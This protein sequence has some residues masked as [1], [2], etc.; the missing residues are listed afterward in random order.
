MNSM[1]S[2]GEKM[3]FKLSLAEW[4]FNQ[5]LFGRVQP[6]LDN[7]DFASEAK[8]LG[9]DAV[10][11]VNQFFMSKAKDAAYIND[12]KKRAADNGVKSLLIMCDQEGNI[13]DPNENQRI[14]V[15]ENHHKWA[16]AAKTLGCHSIRVNAASSG[17]YEEQQK[18]TADG[19]R[20]L[21]EYAKTL[22]LNVLVENHGGNSSIADWLVGV[23]K[24]VDMPNCG[25]LP[26]FGNF[27]RG[28]PG[29]AYQV[30]IYESVKKMMPYAK[31]VSGKCYDFDAEGNETSIDFYKMMNVV[32]DSGYKG[33]VDVEYEGSRLSEEEG[34][35]AAKKLLEKIREQHMKA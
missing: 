12:M 6:A 14:K 33:Y 11:Y 8:R 18:Y 26:D 13:G 30:D 34:I 35:L 27:Q 16:D 28:G 10:E 29:R 15:V 20:R 24:L 17:T 4:S 32:L 3:P 25:T 21:C 19:L 23:M 7:L 31:G 5:R 22:G 2:G 9:F 1:F